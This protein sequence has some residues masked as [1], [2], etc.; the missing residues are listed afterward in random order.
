[1][2][3]H[4]IELAGFTGTILRP[5]DAG[6]DDARTVFNAMVDRRPAVIA[7]CT[8]TADV[9]AAVRFARANDLEI[10]V[11]GGGHS[12]TGAAVVDGGICV[13]LRGLKDMSVDPAQ[14]VA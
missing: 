8:S 3:D 14:R 13:D 11:Y 5:G 2:S 4:V 6:Y 10:S 7:R 12:V 9:S 1:M